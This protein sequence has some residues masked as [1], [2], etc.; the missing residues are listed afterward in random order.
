MA[1][2]TRERVVKIVGRI[3]DGRVAE[4]IATGATPAELMEAFTWLGSDE[5]LGG[6]LEHSLRGR[7]AQLYDIL[8]ADESEDDDRER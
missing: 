5:Y 8:A 2:L 3:D 6:E 7:V 4:V 1:S